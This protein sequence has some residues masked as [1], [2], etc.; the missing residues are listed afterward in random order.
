M[1]CGS[2]GNAVGVAFTPE[3]DMFASGTFLAPNSMGAGLRDA[4]V[5]CVDGGE[6]PVRD[7]V[8]NEHKRTGDLLPPLDAPGRGRRQRSDDLPRGALGDDSRGNLFSALFNM[9]KIMRHKLE[10]D[11]RHLRLPQRGF[12]GLERHRLSSDRRSRRRRRQPAGDRHRRLVPHRLP[13]VAN[14]QA[15]GAGRDLSRAPHGHRENDRPA[16]TGNSMGFT[17]S[18]MR[19]R[20]C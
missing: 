4:L 20:S 18:A 2:Q 5:H 3:G 9:H 8:L 10:R 14:R 19:W 1:V 17:E 15:R 16:R 6:Y 12:P 7:R 13:D 11:R